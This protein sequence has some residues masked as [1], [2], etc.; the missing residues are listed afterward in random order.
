MSV[1]LTEFPDELGDQLDQL[2]PPPM[3]AG[4]KLAV[5]TGLVLLAAG[6]T[7]L[8]AGGYLW[9]RPTA[10]TSYSSGQILEIDA[11]RGMTVARVMLPNN[12]QRAIRITD[13][14]LDAPG[15]A[16]VEV[17]V[18]VE[19][20]PETRGDG[21]DTGTAIA[22][23][24]DGSELDSASALPVTI[25]AGATAFLALWFDPLDCSTPPEEDR[26]SGADATW[27]V[28]DARLDFGAGS[29]PPLSR[30]L[31]L[32]QDPIGEQGQPSSIL[33]GDELVTGGHP[34]DVACEVT[35]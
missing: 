34:L 28:A 29:F 19:P 30:W 26:W 31:R 22:T 2:I 33:V 21:D 12:S 9:P 6:L 18:L 27:G 11:E 3:P 5:G 20:A 10:G 16:L 4:R 17:R 8:N 35:R 13:V 14:T 15:A 25:P 7:Y 24:V 23:P 32:D 1:T